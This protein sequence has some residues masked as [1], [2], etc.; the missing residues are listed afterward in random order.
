MKPGDLVWVDG[1]ERKV[2]SV[3]EGHC[4]RSVKIGSR[5]F[6][7]AERT[8]TVVI[9]ERENEGTTGKAGTQAG[10][11]ESSRLLES[12]RRDAKRGL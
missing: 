5:W 11:N 6:E 7:L 8:H 10:R 9:T 2:V 4:W 12:L 3:G 1:A